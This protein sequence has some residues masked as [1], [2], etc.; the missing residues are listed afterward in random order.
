LA[1]TENDQ[2]KLKVDVMKD[3]F[4]QGQNQLPQKGNE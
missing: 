1:K 3:V 4:K 2:A